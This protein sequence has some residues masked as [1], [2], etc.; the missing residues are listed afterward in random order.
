MARSVK[1]PT[2]PVGMVKKSQAERRPFET[3]WLQVLE[4]LRGNQWIRFDKGSGDY[5]RVRKARGE[6]MVTVNRLTGIYEHLVSHF[7]VGTPTAVVIPATPTADDTTKAMASAEAI[8]FFW[9]QQQFPDRFDEALGWL[10]S[11]GTVGIHSY[12]VGEPDRDA[13]DGADEHP[14]GE[15]NLLSGRPEPTENDLTF[16]V[17]SPFDLWFEKGA[18]SPKESAWVA[19]RTY[20]S[21]RELL[22]LYP[23][24]AKVIKGAG[25][26]ESGSAGY[27]GDTRSNPDRP[28]DSRLEVFEIHWRDGRH[29]IVLGEEYLYKTPMRDTK[30]FPIEVVRFTEIPGQL[31]GRGAIEDLLGPQQNYNSGLSQIQKNMRATADTK[32]NVPR[33]AQLDEDAFTRGAGEKVQYSGPTP[34]TPWTPPQL[35]SYALNITATHPMEMIDI[36]GLPGSMGRGSRVRSKSHAEHLDQ[37]ERT[38]LVAAEGHITVAVANIAKCVLELM[39]THFTKPRMMRMLDS[40][41]APAHRLI[42]G[43]DLVMGDVIVEA[44]SL[45]RRLVEEREAEVMQRAQMGLI[46]PEDVKK[47]IGLKMGDEWTFRKWQA[48]AHAREVLEVLR[49]DDGKDEGDRRGVQVLPTDDLEAFIRVFT[50]HMNTEAYYED[51]PL[52]QQRIYEL[53]V[54]V[55]FANNDAAAAA[56]LAQPTVF[57]RQLSPPGM[58]PGPTGPTGAP[59]TAPPIEPPPQPGTTPYADQGVTGVG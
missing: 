42:K 43:T 30:T 4:Y 52:T 5:V 15:D 59:P 35:P 16:D 36:S 27:F 50:E 6:L 49:A 22:E 10:I 25:Y 21:R 12:Y 23:K 31:L 32:I 7:A 13:G 1:W 45:F 11:C 34:P 24:K 40:A 48:L 41:G 29:A 8:R 51:D 57:P 55:T 56:A 39:Q 58:G 37:Q 9:Y 46:A 38:R 14:D 17:V 47:F 18:R 19:R 2:D 53:L 28:P 20:V 54:M 33:M 44:T 26:A 3:M